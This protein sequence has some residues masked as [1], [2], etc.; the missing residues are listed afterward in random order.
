MRSPGPLPDDFAAIPFPVAEALEAGIT[1]DRLRARD[2]DSSI[3]GARMPLGA[4]LEGR[5]R[6]L[7]TVCRPGAVFCGPTAAL[8]HGIPVPHRF[9]EAARLHIAV[10]PD[11]PAV[12][13]AGVVGRRL[14]IPPTEITEVRRIA[15]T[16]LERTW[17]DLAIDLT[18]PEL[19]A[20]ADAAIRSCTTTAEQLHAAADAY[21]DFRRRPKLRGALDLVDPA[22]ESPKESELRALVVLAGLPRP[23]AN[24]EIRDP[25]GRLV[26]RVDL[27]FRE[28]G[29]V[30][31]YHGDHHR[32]DLRQWRRDRT[33]EAE[34]ESLGFHVMEVTQADLDAPARLVERIARNLAR[35]GWHGDPAI[36]RR[37]G[38][39]GGR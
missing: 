10:P 16:G 33:R 27:L 28:F 1:I 17:C 38:R 6:A 37:I 39:K 2:L 22:S 18:V 26:G 34:L 21:P 11:A 23:E 31:E 29:E 20:A 35:R 7:L 15:V 9:R 5:C 19:V 12:R 3:H 36:S 32:T 13:R 25:A 24:V 30:L 8:L 14:R 4:G